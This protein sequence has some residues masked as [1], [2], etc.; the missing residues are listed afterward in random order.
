M[1][2]YAACA[3]TLYILT[4]LSLSPTGT[5]ATWTAPS[6]GLHCSNAGY[7]AVYVLW[8]HVLLVL[9]PCTYLSGIYLF[10]H[11]E[12][13]IL[14][15]LTPSPILSLN[16]TGTPAT[17]IALPHGLHCSNASY[18]AVYVHDL[19]CCLCFYLVH[20]YCSL[21]ESHWDLGYMDCTIARSS[22][23]QCRLYCCLCA[24]TSCAA[25]ASTLYILISHLF[26]YIYIL[27]GLDNFP[28]LHHHQ[29][30]LWVP[31]GP[32]LHGLH[33]HMDFTVQMQVILL[34]MC[35]DL[36]CCLCFYLVQTFLF[37]Y[38]HAG[39]LR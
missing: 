23:F 2:S 20:T 9:L 16:P 8:P 3:S 5:S 35:Y 21:S 22:L 1:T 12:V 36:I 32:Q 26:I 11:Y 7:I 13:E 25:C 37:F 27:W 6:H 28:P 30:F 15:S 39:R 24:M 14:P 18:I 17:W 29:F 38:L 33:Y 19:I 31:L 4:A 34:F 10:I